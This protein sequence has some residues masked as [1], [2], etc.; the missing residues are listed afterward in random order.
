MQ[1][2]VIKTVHLV[3]TFKIKTK[4]K[5]HDQTTVSIPLHKFSCERINGTG[6]KE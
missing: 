6:Y 3:Y 5:V 2:P 4:T 1:I